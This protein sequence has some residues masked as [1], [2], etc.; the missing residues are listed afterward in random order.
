MRLVGL[1]NHA[2]EYWSS[3]EFIGRA[4]RKAGYRLRDM[5]LNQVDKISPDEFRRS[6][7]V[8]FKLSEND[9]D[10]GLTAFRVEDILAKTYKVSFSQIG[11][12]FR[13]GS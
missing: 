7:K 12:P 4:H 2:N 5:L 3:M 13:L 10:A 9:E 8:E 1:E 11:L 6:G